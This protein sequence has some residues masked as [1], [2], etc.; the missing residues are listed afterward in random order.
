[1]AVLQPNEY[2]ISYFDG[3]KSSLTHNAG[4]TDYERWK[5]YDGA[6]S[7][8][9]FWKD[10]AAGFINHYAISGKKVLE[11]GAAKGFIVKDLRDM[12]VDAWGM[13]VSQYAVDNCEPETVPY[14][15]VGDARTDLKQYSN[16]EFDLI[17]TV[18]FI[19]CLTDAEVT[20]L[21][22][23]MTRIS[24]KQ[25][26]VFTSK[27]NPAYYN[28]KTLQE[29]LAFDWPKNTILAPYLKIDNYLTK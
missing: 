15:Q 28:A 24:K 23:Q 10:M 19:E 17:Y 22:P 7:L 25:V 14:L 21:I 12:G 18:R 1:M 20:A 8:G 29:W 3:K 9:E 13:E 5:R 6:N 2:D 11:L 26:H 4:F 16:K 27:I